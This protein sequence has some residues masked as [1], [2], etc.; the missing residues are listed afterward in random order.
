MVMPV[1]RNEMRNL[2]RVREEKDLDVLITC[3]GRASPHNLRE[4]IAISKA[5]GASPRVVET[6]QK[7]TVPAA[8]LSG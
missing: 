8:D 6:L 4:A 2:D 5:I 3:M 7:A 1:I